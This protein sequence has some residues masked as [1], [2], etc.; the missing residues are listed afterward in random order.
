MVV[1]KKGSHGINVQMLQQAL[2]IQAD[3]VFGTITE[4]AVKIFQRNN[5]LIADGIV[6][7]KTWE[8][9]KPLQS[10]GVSI[11]DSHINIHVTHSPNRTPKYIAIHYTA[12]S[13]SKKGAARN[14][15]NVFL[16]RNASADFVVDDKEI[17]QINPDIRNYY[18]WS[19][20]DKKNATSGGGRLYGIANNKNTVSI[21]ICSNLTS[22]TPA[23]YANH[24]GWY[25]TSSALD[26]ALQLVRYLMKMYD[27]SKANVVRH[28]DISGKLCPGIFGWNN[29]LLYNA[30]GKPTKEQNNSAEWDSFWN[31][32]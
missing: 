29:A 25:F 3:G 32:I 22:G 24:K 27:I 1:L 6:G 26:N 13:T 9:L 11:I 18:C 7:P 5:G 31:R 20:G 2:H 8:K 28:Y 30:D 16:S 4:E 19:V 10:Q 12:G 23:K 21:E 17:V 14:T 15:R